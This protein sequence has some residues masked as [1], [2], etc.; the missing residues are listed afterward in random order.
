MAE[1]NDRLNSWN[2]REL[3]DASA[4]KIG[5]ITGLA[6]PRR[7]FGTR[8]L[9]V[10]TADAVR[11]PVPLVE[12]RSSGDRLVLPYPKSYIE[13]GTA[14]SHDRPLTQDEERRLG[15]HY[16]FYDEAPGAS[17]CQ[18]CGL[19]RVNKQAAGLRLGLG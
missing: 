18:G 7:R 14:I 12:V 13:S 8:W 5:T 17:C 3:F 6:F 4:R 9:L 19:C 1:Q 16:G 11:L 15:L 10:E 2:G